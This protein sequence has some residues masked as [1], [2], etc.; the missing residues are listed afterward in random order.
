MIPGIPVVVLCFQ[1][2]RAGHRSQNQDLG[3]R[4]DDGCHREKFVGLFQS[5]HTLS[6]LLCIHSTKTVLEQETF[7]LAKLNK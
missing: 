3:V 5:E 6:R 7:E 4:I 2:L 1:R